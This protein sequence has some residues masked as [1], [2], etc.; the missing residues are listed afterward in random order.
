MGTLTNDRI[1]ADANAYTDF[2]LNRPEVTGAAIGTTGYCFGGRESI[3]TA[4]RP[5]GKN[6]A[7]ASF[8]R[9]GVSAPAHPP[10]PPPPPPP[11]HPAPFPPPRPHT[12]PLPPP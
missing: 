9:G 5:D 12:P 2:L 10:H 4:G 6:P 11:N 8:P 3:G 7:A 1:I